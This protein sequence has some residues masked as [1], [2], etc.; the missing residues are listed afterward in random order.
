LRD[1]LRAPGCD[2]SEVLQW[3]QGWKALLPEALREQGVV[4]KHL[5]QGLEVMKFFM[6]KASGG[7]EE[8]DEPPFPS[9]ASSSPP[10]VDDTSCASPAAAATPPAAAAADEVSL[11][12]SDYLAEV[13]GEE[14]LVFRPKKALH[15]G[16]QVYQFGAASIYV[17]RN[18]VYAAPKVGQAGEWRAVSMD[19]VLNLARIAPA[20]GAARKQ[21]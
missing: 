17:E 8:E 4:Q 19:E 12:L 14:G 21:R 3:Y 10:P 11:S 18:L 9:V 6:A 5:T 7:A 15:N 16:K 2:F 1:W 20:A 13:A